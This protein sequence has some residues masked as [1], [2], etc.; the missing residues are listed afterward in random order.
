MVNKSAEISLRTQVLTLSYCTSVSNKYISDV[1]DYSISQIFCIRRIAK[2]RGFDP[3][4]SL[5][6]LNKYT[7]HEDRRKSHSTC[8]QE[9]IR[10][11]K[12]LHRDKN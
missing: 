9:S 1:T 12:I 10:P 2:E 8:N 7:R 4:K 5:Q 3:Q 6:I 11:R